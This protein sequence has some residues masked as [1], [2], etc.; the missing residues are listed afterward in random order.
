MVFIKALT[1]WMIMFCFAVANGI[2][3]EEILNTSLGEMYALP[4]SGL[5]L[6][7]IIFGITYKAV[8]YFISS[9]IKFYILLG[10]F[11]L[12]LTLAF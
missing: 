12:G 5:I 6:S 9:N 2:F 4:L 8:D 10:L 11:W 7:L 1:A 3:R